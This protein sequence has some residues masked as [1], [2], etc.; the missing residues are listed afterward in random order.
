MNY[1]LKTLT[2][3]FLILLN[4]CGD[5]SEKKIILEKT[6]LEQQMIE[7]YKKGVEALEEGDVLYAATNFKM[8]QNLFP[9][10][11][12]AAKSNIMAAYAYYSQDYYGDA[13]FELEQFIKTYPKN[14][15]EAYAYYLVALCHYER[16]IDEKKDLKP[17][18]K[19]KEYFKSLVEM[20]PSTDFA[21]DAKFKIILIENIMASKEIYIAK[22]YLKKEKWI[23]AINRFKNVLT[24]YSETQYV[25]EAIHRLVEVYYKIGLEEESRKYAKLL[26]YNY[27]SSEWYEESYKVFNKEYVNSKDKIIKNKGNRLIK[28]FK[29]LFD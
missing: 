22:Y 16:I 17:L 25:E 1:I 14:K 13:I 2:I 21:I 19:S 5:K 3:V 18:I 29:K 6:N 7:A 8:A 26:G 11:D 12:W 15:Y 27:L 28:N 23:P 24:Y 9:Q 20:H 4:S 10:S